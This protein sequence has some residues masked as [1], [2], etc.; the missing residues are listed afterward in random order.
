MGA[1]ATAGAEHTIKQAEINANRKTQAARNV[2]QGAE[3][4][5]ARFSASL[6]N[7][8]MM[9]ATGD[10]INAIAENTGALTGRG[11]L[12]HPRGARC[13]SGG[14]RRNRVYGRC[15]GGGRVL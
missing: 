9:D 7:R 14:T 4:E 2:R 1:I 12:W 10:R 11:Y 13:R 8:R 15:G 6:G 5:L 3:S